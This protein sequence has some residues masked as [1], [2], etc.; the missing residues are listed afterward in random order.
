MYIA[1]ESNTAFH[2]KI[3]K[4]P[5]FVSRLTEAQ[6]AYERELAATEAE[7]RMLERN[8][9]K[10]LRMLSPE[11]VADLLEVPLDQVNKLAAKQASFN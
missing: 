6:L 9:P 7:Q 3:S 4:S 8:I 10:L 11:E 1:T 5:Y 2:E